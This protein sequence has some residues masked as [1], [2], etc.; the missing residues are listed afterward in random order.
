[1]SSNINLVK[2]EFKNV[3]AYGEELTT[4]EFKNGLDLFSGKNGRGKSTLGDVVCYGLYGK[5]FR[6]IKLKSMVNTTNN[7]RMYV[8]IT[9]TSGDDT[10]KVVRTMK[11]DN[12]EIYKNDELIEQ[13]ARKDD[14][15]NM[16]ESDIL[17]TS[18]TVFRQLIV[19]GANMEVSKNF[20]D[21]NKAEKEDILQTLTD[22]KIFTYIKDVV[23]SRMKTN[24]EQKVLVDERT[25]ST[26]SIILS[27]TSMKQKAESHNEKLKNQNDNI[28]G[29]KNEQILAHE[30]NI[31]KHRVIL[32]LVKPMV[33]PYKNK[34]IELEKLK[35]NTQIIKTNAI[36][37]NNSIREQQRVLD[38]GAECESC[39]HITLLGDASEK[40]ILILK[41]EL[42]ALK[43]EATENKPLID[44]LTKEIEDT[45]ID[46]DR[47]KSSNTQISM[48][49]STITNLKEEI[50]ILE[51]L[52]LMDFDESNLKENEEKMILL[53]E[54][55]GTITKDQR[56]LDI[57]KKYVESDDLKGHLISQ[58]LPILNKWI[59]TFLDKFGMSEFIFTIGADLKEQLVR[60]S[61]SG[62]FNGLS[63]GQKARIKFSL[64]FAFL[65]LIENKNG[66][67]WNTLFLDEVL[68][69]SLDYEGRNEL[70]NIIKEEFKEKDIIIV[71]H[72]QDIQEKVEMFNRIVTF[73]LVDDFSNIKVEEV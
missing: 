46:I 60:T 71:S 20:M 62:E 17:N 5:P 67:T 7:K 43:I 72:N 34:K 61:G 32:E 45:S 66:V 13:E 70:L 42:N 68:D 44:T 54:E 52:T 31:E 26:K 21:L 2:A 4:Y 73:A 33:Q 18:E 11:P 55:Q 29:H 53:C 37:I 19:L 69:S 40:E 47:A 41:E 15:Q 58:Q 6:K 30:S 10:Y 14:Y 23:K 51:N 8:A 25:H 38:N 65:K 36:N 24:K 64:M 49:L 3:F 1:M 28:I 57:I 12:F 39:G 59:N 56:A 9:F 48:L 16:L 35:E 50:L 63:N 27:E 22:T